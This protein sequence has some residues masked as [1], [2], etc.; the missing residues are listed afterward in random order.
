[1]SLIFHLVLGWPEYWLYRLALTAESFTA[2][3]FA[4]AWGAGVLLMVIPA[5]VDTVLGGLYATRGTRTGWTWR[6]R[7]TDSVGAFLHPR[8][9]TAARHN[10]RS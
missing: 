6:V 1:M 2:G 9:R 4:A 5:V 3:Q 7:F 8:N 10:A